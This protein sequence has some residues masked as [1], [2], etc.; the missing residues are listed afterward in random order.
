MSTTQPAQT[1]TDLSQLC[2]PPKP[3][4]I[5]GTTYWVPGSPPLEWDWTFQELEKQLFDSGG[6]REAIDAIR[7]H[8]LQLFLFRQPDLRDEINEKLGRLDLVALVRAVR[9][10]YSDTFDADGEAGEVP[11]PKP[12]TKRGGGGTRSTSRTRS[13]SRSRSSG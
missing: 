3:V 5:F 10:I 1:I 9:V 11:P 4:P 12:K 6:S 7:E 2:V 8:L 13:R